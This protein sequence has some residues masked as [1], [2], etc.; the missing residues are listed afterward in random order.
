MELRQIR[1]YFENG[2]M[3]LLERVD[4]PMGRVDFTITVEEQ[5]PPMSF[6]DWKAMM[7]RLFEESEGE[8]L[9][10]EAFLRKREPMRAP[11]GLL[12]G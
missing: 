2:E 11:H 5:R 6:A 3:H 7:D 12:D 9:S 1:G 4:F 10:D 8:E